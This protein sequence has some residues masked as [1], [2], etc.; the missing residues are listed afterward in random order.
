MVEALDPHGMVLTSNASTNK[1]FYIIL[2]LW[3][4]RWS[5]HHAVMASLLGPD[6][7]S[8]TTLNDAAGVHMISWWSG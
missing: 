3:T 7:G 6:L 1:V 8:Q 2:L 4:D 5:H